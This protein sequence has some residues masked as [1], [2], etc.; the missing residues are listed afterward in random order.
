MAVKN[1]YK[2]KEDKT[3]AH[4]IA[5]NSPMFSGSLPVCRECLA[6]MIAAAPPE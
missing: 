6:K 5:V 2:C 1:C 3:T 4:Y